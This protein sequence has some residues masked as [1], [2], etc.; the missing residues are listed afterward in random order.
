M[1]NNLS[2]REETILHNIIERFIRTATPVGSRFI[3]QKTEIGLSPAT[4]RNVMADLEEF[5]YLAHP[6]TSAGRVPTDLGYRTYID[7][8]MEPETVSFSHQEKILQQLNSTNEPEEILRL[9]SKII[10]SITKQLSI[11]TIPRFEKTIL[12]KL[13]LVHISSNKIVVLLSL[14]NGIVKTAMIE[15]HEEISRFKIDEITTVLNEKLA[16]LTISEIRETFKD[17]IK[18]SSIDET[19][20]IRLFVDSVDKIFEPTKNESLHINIPTEVLN[21]PEFVNVNQF[22]T[23][24]ELLENKEMVIHIFKKNEMSNSVKVAIG[25]ETGE[26]RLEQ[27]SVVSSNY[28]FG[29]ET[30]T[31]GI[32]GPRRMQYNKVMPLVDYVAHSLSLLFN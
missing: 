22:R 16:G 28:T 2:K 24:V 3:S 18:N 1:N 30:G 21:Q 25:C 23:I 4:I 17:R 11:V 6:H 8:L 12:E 10:S 27:F 14:D 19:S 29:T 13:E 9:T 7:K 26:R 20:L 5:G 15:I 32:I 31:I